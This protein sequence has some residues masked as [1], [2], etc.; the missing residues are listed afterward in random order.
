MRTQHILFNENAAL[1]GFSQS[2]FRTEYVPSIDRVGA[3]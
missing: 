3:D 1:K 2:P